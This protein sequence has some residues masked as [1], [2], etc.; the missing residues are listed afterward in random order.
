MER[1]VIITG[2]GRGIGRE[3]AVKS[4]ERGDMAVI[5]DKDGKSAK[6]TET[7]IKQSGFAAASYNADLTNADEVAR[8]FQTIFDSTGKI[9]ALVNNAGFYL[10]KPVEELD[11][12][13]WKQVIDANLTTAFL[14]SLEAFR[15][16][17][18]KRYGKIVNISSSTIFNSGAALCP[19]ITAK[20]GLIGL[21][22]ALAVDL[23]PYN[24]TVNALAVGLTTTEYA[25]QV[26]GEQRFE[27]V[28]E[29]R[30]IKRDQQPADLVGAT[31]FLIDPASDYITGQTLSVDGGLTFT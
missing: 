20:S 27:K 7:L 3:I 9:D 2:A 22:R 29:R 1:V 25:Y 15:Y 26:F 14:C 11:I 17:K 30:A 28:K 23:G 13:F 21:T 6:E 5:I 8:V 31:F 10:Q 18:I 12:H 19:Y 24:I 16:M 4:A